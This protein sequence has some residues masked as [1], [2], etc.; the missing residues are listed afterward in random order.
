MIKSILAAGM[1]VAG[2]LAGCASLSPVPEKPKVELAGLRIEHL[3]LSDP[4]LVVILRLTNP[5]RVTLPVNTL[6]L[7]VELNDRAFAEGH[8]VAPVTLP[9][10]GAALMEVALHARSDVLL[11]TAREMLGSP[12]GTV[13]YRVRGQAQ[14]S[15]FNLAVH[16]DTPGST[17]L[18]TLLRR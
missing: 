18:N 4:D 6:E 13:R 15:S 5:N 9:A 10:Q 2:G 7:T 17:D 8:S 14:V 11:R 1:I 3:R 12:G 16:F